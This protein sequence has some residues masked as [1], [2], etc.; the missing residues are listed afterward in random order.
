MAIFVVIPP[1]P[2]AKLDTAVTTHFPSDSFK[3]PSAAWVIS[4]DGTTQ[5]LSNKLGITDQADGNP[6]GVPAIIFSTAGYWG[7]GPAPLWEW[8]KSKLEAKAGG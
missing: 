6:L 3:L 5:T 1:A 2:S 8:L 7:R 4:S